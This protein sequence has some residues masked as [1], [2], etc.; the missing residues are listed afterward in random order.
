ML[1]GS[2]KLYI[3][4][5]PHT[6]ALRTVLVLVTVPTGCTYFVRTLARKITIFAR[7]CGSPIPQ[8]RHFE[9][10]I[11]LRFILLLLLFLIMPPNIDNK[12]A[13]VAAKHLF[14][15]G[16]AASIAEAAILH[17]VKE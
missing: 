2:L 13:L 11:L 17:D 7:A 6:P 14:L 4:S 3:P 15:S 12:E 9:K 1:L 8:F 5:C 16:Q 10:K